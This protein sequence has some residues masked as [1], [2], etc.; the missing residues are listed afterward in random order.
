MSSAT[1]PFLVTYIYMALIR[2]SPRVFGT[3]I[4]DA[5]II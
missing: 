2:D 4:A 5:I 1:E 3:L